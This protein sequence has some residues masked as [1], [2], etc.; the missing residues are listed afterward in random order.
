LQA[1]VAALTRDLPPED[2]RLDATIAR[3]LGAVAT[4]K[5]DPSTAP[6]CSPPTAP[7]HKLR[8]HGGN[9]GPSLDGLAARN[10]TRL[11]EDILDPSRNVDPTFRL[12][13]V[14]LRNGESVAGMNLR[15]EGGRVRLTDPAT[16]SE[17]DL[18][19]ADVIETRT[20][21]ISPMPAGFDS[22]LTEAEF[23]DLLA[24]LRQAPSA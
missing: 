23:V 13:A 15:R 12:G 10:L 6:R 8:D 5:G 19:E 20:E 3:R 16:A 11:V 24:C 17:R 22:I 21:A 2:A 1:E 4:R 7:C 18:A 14:R 9:I